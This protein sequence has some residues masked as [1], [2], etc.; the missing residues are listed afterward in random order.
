MSETP[1]TI[2]HNPAC[3]T[4]RRVLE[5]IRAAG[6]EPRIVEYLKEG[7]TRPQLLSLLAAMNARPRDILRVKAL[8]PDSSIWPIPRPA[9]RRS[10]TP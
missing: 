2:F 8:G 1:I 5:A 10:S 4:S 9:T 3:G 6:R 7:W